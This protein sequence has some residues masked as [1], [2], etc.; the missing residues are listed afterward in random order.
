MGNLEGGAVAITAV[1]GGVLSAGVS[2][3]QRCHLYWSTF[4][5]ETDPGMYP[6]LIIFV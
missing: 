3:V 1:V 6:L 4:Q 2:A 5:Y